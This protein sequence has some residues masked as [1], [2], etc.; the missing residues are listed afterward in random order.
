MIT[1]SKRHMLPRVVKV[2]RKEYFWGVSAIPG[3]HRK[4]QSLPL[5]HLLRD[6]L[7][8]GDKEREI[9][10]ILTMGQIRLDGKVVKQ[11]RRGV[12]FMDVVSIPS[13]KKHYRII[14]DKLG[15]LI[16]V[17]ETEEGSKLKPRKLVNKVSIKGGK[18]M[19]VFHDGFNKISDMQMETGDVALFDLEK[20][21][22]K[23]VTKLT[24]GMKVFLTGGNHVGSLALVKDVEVSRSSASN[25]VHTEEGFATVEEYVFPIGNMSLNFSEVKGGRY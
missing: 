11:K 23:N 22:V 16:P 15:R 12:G 17:E 18:T 7:G 1:K 3:G 5:M 14:Y 20:N 9:S 25:L 19:L 21:S 24:E 6:Y 13:V 2:P 8:V 4:D 10:R